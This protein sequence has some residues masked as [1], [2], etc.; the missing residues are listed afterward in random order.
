MFHWNN[1]IL[2]AITWVVHQDVGQCS[3]SFSPCQLIVSSSF[4]LLGV[5]QYCEEHS[6]N[7]NTALQSLF[8]LSRKEI[9]PKSYE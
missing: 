7:L 3:T 4:H 2:T 5:H 9:L 1:S 8:F 6:Q